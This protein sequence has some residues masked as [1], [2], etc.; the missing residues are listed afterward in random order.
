MSIPNKPP[1][2][3]ARLKFL[4]E[5]E[6]LD[7][8][9]EL[10]LDRII[11]TIAQLFRVPIATLTLI[12]DERQWFKSGV[13]IRTDQTSRDIAFCAHTVLDDKPMIVENA[14]VDSRFSNNPL[15]TGEP[16]VRF[17]AGAPLIAPRNH[18][19]GSL[20]VIDIVP[21]S[22]LTEDISVLRQLA[23]KA[24]KIICDQGRTRAGNS[25]KSL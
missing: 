14:L 21:R 2:E 11:F 25:T 1:N 4:H 18:I 5:L 10:V 8:E 16:K 20:C 6:I 7:T 24:T 17:Y 23:A 12:D 19:I 3:S 9:P 13:G 15:V 22:P